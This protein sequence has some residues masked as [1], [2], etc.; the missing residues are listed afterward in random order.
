MTYAAPLYTNFPLASG[1]KQIAGLK[2]KVPGTNT[3]GKDGNIDRATWTFWRC[4][5]P[6]AESITTDNVFEKFQAAFN[7][8]TRGPDAPDL[9]VADNTMYT[10]ISAGL[11]AQQR[12]TG[13]QG[14][15]AKAGW[16][17]LNILNAEVVLDGGL[18]GNAPSN[19]AYL[20]NTNYLFWRPFRKR[21]MKPLPAPRTIANQDSIIQLVVF[22]GNLTASNLQLQAILRGS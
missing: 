10:K 9:I 6:A 22:A 19:T 7:A 5:A 13:T 11:Q 16:P 20:L 15:M 12:F 4:H 1:G 3:S 17:T 14:K 21:N 2:I 18:G 8:I